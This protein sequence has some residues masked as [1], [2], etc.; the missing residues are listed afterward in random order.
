[1]NSDYGNAVSFVSVLSLPYT[2]DRLVPQLTAAIDG[3]TDTMVTAGFAKSHPGRP[4]S[5]RR[6]RTRHPSTILGGT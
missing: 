2:L 3:K 6:T 1:V 4:S 5:K